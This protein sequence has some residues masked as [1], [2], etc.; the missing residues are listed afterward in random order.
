MSETG[1]GLLEERQEVMGQMVARLGRRAVVEVR[2]DVRLITSL[3]PR[4]PARLVG[5]LAL[6]RAVA[7]VVHVADAPSARPSGTR[8]YVVLELLVGRKVVLVVAGLGLEVA[9]VLAQLVPVVDTPV[10]R[11]RLTG[12]LR[13]ADVPQVVGKPNEMKRPL[14]RVVIRLQVS[15][16]KV[17]VL[18]GLPLVPNT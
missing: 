10:V 8:T 11:P 13:P 7:L 5:L 16:P 4:Q 18:R 3:L 9:L 6:G 1:Q 12:R 2:R 14:A 17:E 15:P